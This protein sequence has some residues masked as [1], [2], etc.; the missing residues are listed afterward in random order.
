[1]ETVLITGAS[2]G[3]GLELAR[4]F[5]ADGCDLVLV[6]RREDKLAA[7]AEE[8][9]TQHGVTCLVLGVDLAD[10]AGPSRIH[11]AVVARGI[12]VDVL[13]NNAGFGLVGP[14]AQLP[15]Q[16]QVDIVLVNVAALTQLTSLFVPGMLQRHRGGVL[17]VGSTAGFQPGPYLAVYYASKAYVLSY[18][19]ALAEELRGSGVRVCCLLPGPTNTEFGTVSGVEHALLF[20]LGLMSARAVARAGHRGFR[21]GRLLVIPGVLN[22]LTPWLVRFSPRALARKFTKR[23]NKVPERTNHVG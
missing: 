7:L 23:L 12:T 6:A 20:K 11:Q 4:L 8:L 18:T 1:M 9:Q 15:V 10:P 22:K 14:V 5:A 13:V 21:R 3:I 19:E 2:A 17:N 16:R